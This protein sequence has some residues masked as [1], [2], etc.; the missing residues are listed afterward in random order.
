ML[1][2]KM[3]Y[4]RRRKCF[5][6]CAFDGNTAKVKVN[7]TEC[8]TTQTSL[9]F[10]KK[11]ESLMRYKRKSKLRGRSFCMI[12][13]PLRP[14]IQWVMAL[15]QQGGGC[16]LPAHPRKVNNVMWEGWPPPPHT[17]TPTQEDQDRSGSISTLL[18]WRV[19][20]SYNLR[21]V[22]KNTVLQSPWS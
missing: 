15:S 5:W 18:W 2:A 6:K 12:N 11:K 3:Y 8:N 9:Y 22:P 16:A 17:H 14:Q 7:T 20:K 13:T 1:T 4:K 21:P 10:V 19:S